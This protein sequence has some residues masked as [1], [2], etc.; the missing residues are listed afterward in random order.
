MTT[1]SSAQ[2]ADIRDRRDFLLASKVDRIVSNSLRWADMGEAKQ[3]EW[4][5]YRRALLD[6]TD[7]STFPTS[8]AWPTKPD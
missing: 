3:A 6:I 7:Q 1:A 8:V 2:A 4:V 5:A